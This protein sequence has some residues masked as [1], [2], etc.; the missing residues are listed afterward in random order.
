MAINKVVYGTDTLIDLSPTTATKETVISGYGCFGS[1]GEWIDGTAELV[2]S[3]GGGAYNIKSVTQS[4]GTQKLEI[5][6]ASGSG[7]EC[8]HYVENGECVTFLVD[9]EPYAISIV[10]DNSFV[11]EPVVP[12]PIEPNTRFRY[13]E[14]ANGDKVLFPYD[15]NGNVTL[16]AVF[17]VGWLPYTKA[18]KA[19]YVRF[20]NIKWRYNKDGTISNE[21]TTATYPIE[22]FIYDLDGNAIETQA[23]MLTGNNVFID[24][25][26][27]AG[28]YK[29]VNGTHI[30]DFGSAVDIGRICMSMYGFNTREYFYKISVSNDNVNWLYLWNEY[31]D[32][33]HICTS[34]GVVD[35]GKNQFYTSPDYRGD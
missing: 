10:K 21:T 29:T 27:D 19:R 13:W 30:I 2:P 4:D 25:L 33:P 28:D 18:V 34:A 6:D 11:L 3:A 12:V 31:G 32:E 17:S 1:N 15:P 7:G 5:V 26:A 24:G 22:M 14:N 23:T 20:E 35:G 9:G 16:S 8:T